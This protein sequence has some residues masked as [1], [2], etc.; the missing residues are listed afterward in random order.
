MIVSHFIREGWATCP[1]GHFIRGLHR[2]GGHELNSIQWVT[3]CKPAMHPHWY[4]QC[5]DQ[6]VS[7]D[8][9]E[10]NRNG[11][12]VAG[13]HRGAS[14]KLSSI[15]QLRCCNMYDEANL[16]GED[17]L[18]EGDT[19]RA[20]Y[21]KGCGGHM[22]T[23]RL[24]IHYENFSFKVKNM[25]YLEPE[26]ES[27]KPIIQD[28]GVIN[29]QDSMATKT[30][31]KRQIKSVR[32]VTQSS[33]SRFKSGFGASVTLSYKSPGMIAGAAPETFKASVTLSGGNEHAELNTEKN[34]DI[35]WDIVEVDEVQ[36]TNGNSGTSY[37]IT[38]SKTKVN[39]PYIATIQVQFTATLDGYLVWGG[40]PNGENPNYHESYRG[41]GD[42][43]VIKYKIGTETVP[44]YK[45]LKLASQ[46]GDS[47]WFLAS[48]EAKPP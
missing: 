34:G 29:N 38:T 22:S 46:R 35:N 20:H 3:C 33:S 2:G 24:K 32:T 30:N 44:F 8:T 18:R 28:V 1:S 16:F 31:I 13:I 21:Q 5:Y 15:N 25:E 7:G 43:P 41:S 10:C 17:F 48:T 9:L 37:Q 6:D 23:T 36:T 40:G 14:Q 12:Y 42:R 26:I 45:F 47:P 4:K 39:V 19:W 27:M 11:F